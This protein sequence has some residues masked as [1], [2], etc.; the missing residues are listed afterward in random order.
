MFIVEIS[1]IQP[2]TMVEPHVATH[3]AW[4]KKHLESGAIV[5]AGPKKSGLGGILGMRAPDRAALESILAEDSYAVARV[6]EYHVVDFD[7][8]AIAPG[9]EV[10]ASG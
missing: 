5:F 9:L 10:L 7:C 6:A 3:G 1:Y 4:V 8:R 2:V